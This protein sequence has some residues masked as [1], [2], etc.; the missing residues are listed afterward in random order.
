MFS[1]FSNGLL[2]LSYADSYTILLFKFLSLRLIKTSP[3]VDIMDMHLDM[4]LM[5]THQEL[6]IQ[7]CTMQAT[8]DMETTSRPLNNHL[9]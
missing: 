9:R 7:T 5:D 3:M 2:V 6:R 4:K 1:N 8:K